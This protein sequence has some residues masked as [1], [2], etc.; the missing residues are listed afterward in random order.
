MVE[1]MLELKLDQVQT[2]GSLDSLIEETIS[3]DFPHVEP[4]SSVDYEIKAFMRMISF[5]KTNTVKIQFIRK[6]HSKIA[7]VVPETQ[8]LIGFLPREGLCFISSRESHKKKL[9]DSNDI[10]IHCPLVHSLTYILYDPKTS[11]IWAYV[12]PKCNRYCPID[13]NDPHIRERL[14]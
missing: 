9:C 3:E 4:L 6:V 1:D 12:P 7:P 10:S 13:T 5:L 11:T 2:N 8:I 14:F